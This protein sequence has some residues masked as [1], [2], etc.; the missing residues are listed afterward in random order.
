MNAPDPLQKELQRIKSV[1]DMLCTA[2][3]AL[4]DKYSRMGLI[5]DLA[6]LFISAWL[7]ALAFVDPKINL[8]LT[9]FQMDGQLWIGLLAVGTFIL[10]IFQIKTDWKARSDSHKRALELFA[11]VKLEAG[12]LLASGQIDEP[13]LNRIHVLYGMASALGVEVP[14]RDF[15]SQKRRHK[16]KI[17]VS[18]H[19]DEHPA[20]SIRMFRF[21]LWWRDNFRNEEVE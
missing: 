16:M 11:E 17:A 15:L 2:H 10:T 14:E 1:S 4:R 9:P 6:I 7:V 18:K 8:I 12:A 19:L 21:K 20:T 13:G 5:L 3:A